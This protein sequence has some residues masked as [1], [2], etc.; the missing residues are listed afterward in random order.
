MRKKSIKIIL[1][2][3]FLVTV[4]NLMNPLIVCGKIDTDF[5][6]DHRYSSDFATPA[7]SILGAL[8]AVGIIMSVAML[9]I[10]GIKFLLSSAEERAEQ[11]VKFIYYI[12]GAILVGGAPQVINLIYEIINGI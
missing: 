9:M 4:I 5:E 3:I 8:K 2:T 1:I 7:S 6:I 10:I 11:K 12:I